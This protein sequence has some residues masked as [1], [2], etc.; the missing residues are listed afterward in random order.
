MWHQPDNSLPSAPFKIDRIDHLVLTVKNID[1]T[2]TFYSNVLG[3]EIVTFKENRKALIFGNQKFN[4][5]EAGKEFEP[6][7]QKPTPGSIDICLISETPLKIIAEHLKVCGVAIEEGPVDRTG[8]IGPITSLYF[9]D[10]D[11]NLIE[12]SN[13]CLPGKSIH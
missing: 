2:M 13:Y 7:A 1:A 3:M 5:H 8:A 9:R 4:L 6:K 11:N 12:V 10:P